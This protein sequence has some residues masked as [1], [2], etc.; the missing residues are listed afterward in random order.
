MADQF[1]DKVSRAY[2]EGFREV[3][4]IGSVCKFYEEHGKDAKESNRSQISLKVE[5]IRTNVEPDKGT[6]R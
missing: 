5:E 1:I 3:K 4:N 6:E 2:E